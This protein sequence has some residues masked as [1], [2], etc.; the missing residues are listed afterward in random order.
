MLEEL[1]SDQ[2]PALVD[3][4]KALQRWRVSPRPLIAVQFMTRRAKCLWSDECRAVLEKWGSNGFAE[5]ARADMNNKSHINMDGKTS[6]EKLSG[7]K[8]TE[9]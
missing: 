7:T 5:R 8:I 9:N 1:K 4:I 3:S 2:E 6:Y